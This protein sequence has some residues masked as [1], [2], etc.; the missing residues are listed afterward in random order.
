MKR[1]SKVFGGLTLATVLA[2]GIPTAGAVG[3]RQASP[4]TV[5]V[6]TATTTAARPNVLLVMADDMRADEIKWMPNVRKYITDRGSDFRNSFAPTPLCCPNRASFLTGKFS[7]NHQV[8]WHDSPFGYGSFDDRKTIATSLVGAGYN[9]GYVGKYLN[10]YGTMR[11]KANPD[12][13][14]STFVPAGW[15]DW[16][17]TPDNTGLPE[18]DPRAGGTYRFFDTTINNNGKLEGHQGAYNSDVLVGETLK[19][20]KRFEGSS[21]PWFI[22]LN[23]LAPHHGA[24]AEKDDPYLVTPAR[25]NWVKGKFNSQIGRAPGVPSSGQPEAD[26]SDKFRL[27]RIRPNLG[28]RERSAIRNT[29]RQRA[30]TLFVLDQQLGKVF[31]HLQSTG[32]LANTVLAFTSDNGYLLGEHRWQSGKIQGY[33]PSYRVPLVM[34]G[35]GIPVRSQMV[36]VSSVDLTSTILEWTGATLTGTDGHSFAGE[37]AGTTGWNRAIGY[38]SYTPSLGNDHTVHG[39]GTSVRTAIG[40]RTAQYFYV[41]YSNGEIEFFDLLV[42]PAQLR[43]KHADPKYYEVRKALAGVWEQ[44]RNCARETCDIPLPASLQ[45]TPERTA[46]LRK[47]LSKGTAAYYS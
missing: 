4:H 46:E 8:W 43:S 35:P 18:S 30:E 24:P 29:A 39:F 12:A 45:T 25:P 9:T 44:Y 7:H 23:S 28:D 16:R 33:E 41:R 21:K 40:V 37:L 17:G 13:K 42:D 19:I 36:P 22:N 26:V 6:R 34:A 2:V 27:T 14:P 47:I 3:G 10:G 20:I 1:T 15:T 32:E 5:D 38:E 11:P 31:S